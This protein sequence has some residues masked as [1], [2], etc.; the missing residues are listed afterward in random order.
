MKV[1]RFPDIARSLVQRVA[2]GDAP[3]EV[4]DVGGIVATCRFDDHSVLH[5]SPSNWACRQTLL[6]VPAARSSPGFPATVTRPGLIGCL[7]WRWLP[8]WRPGTTHPA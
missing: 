4:G 5:G 1:D 3:R 8:A 7:Y 2:G 6:S